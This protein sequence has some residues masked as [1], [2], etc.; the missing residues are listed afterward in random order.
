MKFSYPFTVRKSG[1]EYLVTF[2]D[3]PEALTAGQTRK[4]A[5]F[6]AH[7]ALIAALGG[8]VELRRDLPRPS[9]GKRLVHLS[10]LE[11][12]KLGLYMAMRE[13]QLSNV[14]LGRMLGTSEGSIRRL[15]DLDHH[16]KIET[17]ADAL[18]RVFRYEIV[19]TMEASPAGG[20]L[21]RGGVVG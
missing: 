15:L 2:P 1:K 21:D 14:E 8:Y 13:R 19:T 11:A 16:S 4:E 10:P 17:I 18:K 20:W 9:T 7:D 3:V 5:Y 6:L 12:A